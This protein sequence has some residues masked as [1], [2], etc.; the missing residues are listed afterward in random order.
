MQSPFTLQFWRALADYGVI[1]PALGTDAVTWLAEYTRVRRTAFASVLLTNNSSEGASAGGKGNFSQ[2]ILTDA[3]HCHRYNLDDSYTLPPHLAS[4]PSALIE[5]QRAGTSR[6]V[7]LR[8]G[9]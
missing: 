3:L 2:E 1:M 4:Y 8:F 6:G 7:T 9:Q 5:R